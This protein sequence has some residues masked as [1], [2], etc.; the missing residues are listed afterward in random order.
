MKGIHHQKNSVH[1]K[2]P[3]PSLLCEPPQELKYHGEPS[4]GRPCHRAQ[5]TNQ[6][7]VSGANST[8]K[9]IPGLGCVDEENYSV[10]T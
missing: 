1:S 4:T 7:M 2:V 10:Q 8:P 9:E 6:P 3:T 5:V